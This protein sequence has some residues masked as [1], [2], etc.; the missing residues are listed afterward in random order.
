MREVLRV[1]RDRDAEAAL[2]LEIIDLFDAASAGGTTAAELAKVAARATG[3]PVGLQDV[4]NGHTLCVAADQVETGDATSAPVPALAIARRL[5][6][7]NAVTLEL[8]EGAALAASVEIGAG[9]I[10]VAWLLGTA[11]A[12]WRPL[13]YLVVERLAAAL[14]R[15]ALEVRG[16]GTTD[17]VAVERLLAGGLTEYELAHAS[18]RA[19]LSPSHR[20]AVVAL[21]QAP[22]NAV[23]LEALGAIVERALATADVAAFSAVVGRIAVVLSTAGPALDSALRGL[24]DQEEELGFA[25]GAGVS[26][27]ASLD[28]L[29]TAWEQAREAL[30]LREMTGPGARVGA[31]RDLGDLHLLAQIPRHEILASTL[32]TQLIETVGQHGNPSDLDVLEAYLDEGT[33]RRAAVRVFLHHTSV[34]HRIKRLEEALD[35][36]LGHAAARFDVHLAIKLYRILQSRDSARTLL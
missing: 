17:A 9:R 31:F 26:D 28:A 25:I 12:E 33:L 5:R 22:P 8:D 23:S 13:D 18:R 30:A 20:Y 34:E 1:T 19:G 14:A 11:D 24:A 2:W 27:P 10:G 21:E 3:R 16:G 32:L 4:W 29:A 15:H 35:V 36:D 6:G 7:R